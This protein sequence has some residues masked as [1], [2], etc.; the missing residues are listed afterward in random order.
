MMD[1]VVWFFTFHKR[2]TNAWMLQIPFYIRFSNLYKTYATD[3][4][5]LTQ[6]FIFQFY[7]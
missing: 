2:N 4:Y 1:E 6:M 3:L 7:K 5:T